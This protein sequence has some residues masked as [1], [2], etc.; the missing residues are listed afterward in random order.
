MINWPVHLLDSVEDRRFLVFFVDLQTNRAGSLL[1]LDQPLNRLAHLGL[2]W[3]EN[4]RFQTEV[5]NRSRN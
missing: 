5:R 4:L 2:G 1:E 3:E